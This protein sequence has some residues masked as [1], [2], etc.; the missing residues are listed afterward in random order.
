MTKRISAVVVALAILAALTS[1]PVLAQTSDTSVDPEVR[2]AVQEHLQRI[3]AEL[4][5]TGEQKEQL[6][7]ILQSE[8][9]QL[10]SVKNDAS[11][12]PE[13]K[14]AKAQEIHQDLQSQM[15][16]VLTPEQQKKLVAMREQGQ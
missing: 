3:S 8:V 10:Q 12:S 9:R 14:L 5:L 13:Q 2:A 16:S 6:K 7:P 15:A 11:L 4:N 1:V